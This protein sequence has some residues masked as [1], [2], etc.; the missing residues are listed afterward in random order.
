MVFQDG[1]LFDSLTVG[2]NIGYWLFE[3][4]DAGEDEIEALEVARLPVHG[5][6]GRKNAVLLQD[7]GAEARRDVVAS[8]AGAPAFELGR[9]EEAHPCLEVDERDGLGAGAHGIGQRRLGRLARARVE[10]A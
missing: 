9:G 8:L 6:A 5:V 1:A 7:R 2:E 4:S 10:E 3:N